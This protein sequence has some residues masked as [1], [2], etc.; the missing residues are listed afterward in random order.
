MGVDPGANGEVP[1]ARLS[2]V[3]FARLF[4]TPP[5]PVHLVY[6][7]DVDGTAERHLA[8]LVDVAGAGLDGVFGHCAGWPAGRGDPER[9]HFLLQHQARPAAAYVNTVGRTVRQVV[10]E[11]RLRA[12]IEQFLDQAQ[13]GLPDDPLY[14]RAAVQ[15]FVQARP[16]L[17][18]ALA[19]VRSGATA[20][21]GRRLR[22]AAVVVVLLVLLP[23]LLAVAPV[24][25]LL[26]LLHESRDVPISDKPDP[27]RMAEIDAFE[28]RYVQ[29]AFNAVSPIKPGWLR[30]L[31]TR[32]TLG[33]TGFVARNVYDR[34]GLIGLE[35]IHFFRLV[36]LDSGRLMFGS[37]FDGSL[38]SYMDDFVG[39]IARELNA[40]FSN[41]VGYPRTRLLLFGGAE[42]EQEFK[43]Y[44]RVRQVPVPVFYS[45]Y[46]DLTALNVANNA[47]VRAGLS[48]RM[49]KDQAT[50]WLARL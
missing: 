26:L 25:L 1:F 31:T 29:N 44:V 14:L 27:A 13:D 15:A 3:H 7:S 17:A 18:W 6:M 36:L 28:D 34:G 24:Y 4:L 8:D 49:S 30:A 33:A 35:T 10:E 5:D 21:L 47:A 9:L 2:H 39:R 48:G 22:V 11:R 41:A 19:P 37:T 38:E 23:I 40:I 20:R 50:A 46:P 32:L 43:N 42:R 12:A 45:A 16:E